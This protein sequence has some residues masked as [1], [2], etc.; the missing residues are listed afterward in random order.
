MKQNTRPL[1]PHLE[2][3]KF[4]ITMAMSIFHRITGVGLYLGMALL[5][6]WLAASATSNRALNLVYSVLGNWF[7]QLILI[8]FTWALFHHLLGGLRHF[9]WDTGAGFDEKTRFAFAWA[10]LIGGLVLTALV[11]IFFVWL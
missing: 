5:C 7:G 3:Y 2:I 4:Q 9:V 6:W 1:S 10:T 11:W 8:G